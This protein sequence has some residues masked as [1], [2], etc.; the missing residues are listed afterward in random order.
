MTSIS[1]FLW[2]DSQAEEAAELYVSLFDNSWI[3]NI[4]RYP[5]GSPGP[6]GSAMS[7]SFVLDGVRVQALN[8]GPTFSFTEAFS[9]MVS[10]DTQERIDFL[11]EALTRDGGEE[12][13]CGWLKDRFGLSWQ[14]VPPVLGTLLGG[15]DAEGSARAMTAM[16]GMRKLDIAALE[17]AYAGTE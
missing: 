11:W 17:A 10:A 15:E 8:G 16:L 7:V 14:I 1:P 2:F 13:Q 3:V 5:E 4:A 9:F 12:S 6:A